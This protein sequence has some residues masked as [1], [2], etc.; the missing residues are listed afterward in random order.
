MNAR[1]TYHLSLDL[2]ADR[3]VTD[4]IAVMSWPDSSRFPLHTGASEVRD[5]VLADLKRSSSPLIIAGY[6]SLD[7]FVDFVA[8]C[9]PQTKIRI[10]FG[11][12]PFGGRQRT[13]EVRGYSFPKEVADYWLKQ[14]VSLLLS[15]KLIRCIQR[16]VDGEVIARYMSDPRNRLHAKIYVGDEAGTVGSSN[17]TANGLRGQLEANARFTLAKDGARYRELC[18]IAE[19]F[20]QIGTEY[21]QDLIGLLNALLQVVTW[22]EALARACA[23]LLEGD[24]AA[25]YLRTAYLPGEGD[26]WPSQRQGIAQALYVLSRN[27][28]AL[29]ADATGS[30]KTRMGVHLIRAAAEEIVRSGRLRKGKALMICPPTVKES[31]ELEATRSGTALDVVS[32]GSLSHAGIGEREREIE[33]LRRAQILCVDEGHNFLNLGSKR[34]QHLLRNMADH[35][36]LFTATPINRTAVDL[37]RIADMLGADNLEPTTVKAF[38]KILG[39]KNINRSLS[40]D[41]LDL[42]RGEIQKFTVRRTKRMLNELI[43]ERPGAYTDANGRPC[44]FPRHVPEVYSLQ[45]SE[46]DRK[47]AAEIRQLAN[48]LVAATHF[49]QVIEM[50]EALRRRGW[51]EETYLKNRLSSA[52]RVAGYMV[53]AALRSS[54]LALAEHVAGTELAVKEFDLP[55]FRKHTAT[56]NQ[57]K[58]LTEIRGQL[59]RNRLK[60]PLPD[61]LADPELHGAACDSDASIYSQ[62]LELV[63]QMSDGRERTKAQRLVELAAVHPLVLAFDSRPISLAEIRRQIGTISKEQD[64]MVATGD[65]ASQRSKLL[66]S[67]KPGSDAKGIIGLCS[68]SLAEGVNLQQASCMVHLDMPSVVRIAEQRAGRVDRMDSPHESIEAWWP[69]DAPEFALSSD[70]RFI[71]RYETVDSLLGSNMPLPDSM[72]SAV[73]RP[74]TVREIIDEYENVGQASEWDGLHD[75]FAPV[76]ALVK[77]ER[78]LVDERT[79]Q[80]YR[81]QTTRV[82]SRVSVVKSKSPWAFFALAGGTFRAPHWVLFPSLDGK[83]VTDLDE[84]C[85]QLRQRLTGD[86]NDL[87]LDDRVAQQLADFVKKLSS[88]ERALLPRKKQRALEEMEAVLGRF[89]Q[90]VA[91]KQDQEAVD[92]YHAILTMLKGTDAERQ[93][94]WD[95]VASRWL[96]LVRPTWYEKL[97]EPHKRPLLLKDIRQDLIQQEQALRPL[98]LAQFSRSFPMMSS[99]DERISACIIGTPE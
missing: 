66:A 1:R 98:V 75:A 84:V 14:G 62:I 76:R 54:R 90:E 67:F 5:V 16:I 41:E 34:T 21:G 38:H 19:N 58:R 68:D 53:M 3:P 92:H 82:L 71:E 20:W 73:S 48:G 10:L 26:L 91:E 44:R 24:W 28:S 80:Y 87:A 12:E 45:E 69:E 42:L 57:L 2:F 33:A 93:P 74:V 6:A 31:W 70:D 39:V 97:K 50:P 86:V 51:T 11:F 37:L 27:G 63:R 56:G 55:G 77:G 4:A 52:K 81:D 30:G 99:P 32:H 72:Q 18:T 88:T 25:D 36:V 13:Y 15:A 83:A 46:A 79:Y 59:P 61:W 22:Q 23:E 43:A 60:V 17:F 78:A 7:Q 47:L 94:D 29:V 9:K 89:V 49:V 96:D 40:E 85:A 35:V 65:P 95:E 64:V 8:D